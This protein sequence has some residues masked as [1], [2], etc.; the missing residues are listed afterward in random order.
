M[1]K[2]GDHKIEFNGYRSLRKYIFSRLLL[3]HTA[4]EILQ[5]LEDAGLDHKK[6]Q[7]MVFEY[8]REFFKEVSK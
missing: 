7:R 4:Q 8:R 6:S 1:R 5:E 3:G 2:K